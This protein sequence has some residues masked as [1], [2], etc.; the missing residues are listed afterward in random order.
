MWCPDAADVEQVKQME[1]LLQVYQPPPITVRLWLKYALLS[2]DSL[3]LILRKNKLA[4]RVFQ[5]WE[6][7]TISI[8][9]SIMYLMYWERGQV[10]YTPCAV[11]ENN[12]TH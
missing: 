4:I 11:G 5:S 12:K 8:P 2:L 6:I 10:K 7:I 9:V 1:W 3:S